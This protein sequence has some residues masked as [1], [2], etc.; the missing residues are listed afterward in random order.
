MKTNLSNRTHLSKSQM[1]YVYYWYYH[2]AMSHD[3][4]DTI[5]NLIM[6][7]DYDAFL[8]I[9]E[10]YKP[11]TDKNPYGWTFFPDRIS[12]FKDYDLV[13]Q[14]SVFDKENFNKITRAEYECG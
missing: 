2:G 11:G 9:Y 7:H 5:N 13:D 3:A 10:E 14:T 4:A 6:S 8:R 12:C 1:D